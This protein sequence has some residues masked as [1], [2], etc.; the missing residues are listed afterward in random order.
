MVR[1]RHNG[2]QIVIKPVRGVEQNVVKCLRVHARRAGQ[3]QF[4][5]YAGAAICRHGSDYPRSVIKSRWNVTVGIQKPK[6]A[7]ITHEKGKIRFR[8]MARVIERDTKPFFG[9]RYRILM[10]SKYLTDIGMT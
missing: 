4:G 5:L 2:G 9:A 1:Q 10:I 7:V 6:K 3:V 8:D